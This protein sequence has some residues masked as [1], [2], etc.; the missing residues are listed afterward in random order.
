LVTKLVVEWPLCDG[1]GVCTIEAP[2]LL[3]LDDDDNLQVLNEIVADSI[4]AK[5][6]AAV[7]VCPKRALKLVTEG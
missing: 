1:N 5:A 3:Q 4:L 6:E 2:E 7:R